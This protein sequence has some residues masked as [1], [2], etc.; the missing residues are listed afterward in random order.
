VPRRLVVPFRFVARYESLAWWREPSGPRD[1][2]A[3]TVEGRPAWVELDKTLGAAR[4]LGW[5]D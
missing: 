5:L 4:V 1:V 2:V 3:A